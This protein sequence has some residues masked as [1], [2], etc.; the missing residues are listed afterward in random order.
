MLS[1]EEIEKK[2][3]FKDKKYIYECEDCEQVIKE[4]I[5]EYT[6]KLAS[7]HSAIHDECVKKGAQLFKIRNKRK[8]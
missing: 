6:I 1:N 3:Y 8:E 4:P 2:I 7:I 5:E